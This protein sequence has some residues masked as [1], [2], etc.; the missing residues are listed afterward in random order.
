MFNETYGFFYCLSLVQSKPALG[1]LVEKSVTSVLPSQPES[2]SS[3][4]LVNLHFGGRAEQPHGGVLGESLADMISL[5]GRCL[6]VANSIGS[7]LVMLI[8]PLFY[9]TGEEASLESREVK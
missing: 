2:V 3:F 6:D 5:M 7:L 4:A 8:G 1:G 9:V